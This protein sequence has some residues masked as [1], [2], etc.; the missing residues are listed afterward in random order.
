MLY[1]LLA[2]NINSFF[3][4]YENDAFKKIVYVYILYSSMMYY[5]IISYQLKLIKMRAKLT[6]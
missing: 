2:A 4:F 6:L 5:Y 3:K 1:I